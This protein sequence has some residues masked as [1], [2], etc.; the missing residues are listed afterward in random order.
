[1]SVGRASVGTMARNVPAGASFAYSVALRT[2]DEQ[3]RNIEALDTKA[4]VLIAADGLI[5]ALLAGQERSLAGVPAAVLVAIIGAV[6][7]SLIA[8]LLSFTTR[9]YETAPNP[10]AAIHLMTAEPAWLEWRF[11]GSMQDAIRANRRKLRTKTRFL[12]AALTALIAGAMVL[13]G[14]SL[15]STITVG[16]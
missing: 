14:Y 12:S 8:A 6:T 16:A 11:L 15:T 13:G 2:L 5:L 1:M 4:G 3:L 10:V 7:S 9:R